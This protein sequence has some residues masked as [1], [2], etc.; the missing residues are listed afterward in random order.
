MRGFTKG[1]FPGAT[2][3][4]VGRLSRLVDVLAHAGRRRRTLPRI[5]RRMAVIIGRR[6]LRLT[7]CGLCHGRDGSGEASI[8]RGRIAPNSTDL[9]KDL[10]TVMHSRF[11]SPRF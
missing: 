7:L 9:D 8:L 1:V 5:A 11:P 4:D 2:L 6:R 3:A 10:L